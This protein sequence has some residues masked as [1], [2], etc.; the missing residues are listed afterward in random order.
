MNLDRFDGLLLRLLDV[1]FG[2]LRLLLFN[3]L[4]LLHHDRLKR[5]SLDL[6]HNLLNLMFV[7][8]QVKLKVD[9]DVLKKLSAVTLLS[10]RHLW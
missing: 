9:L 6:S 1:A 10:G 2:D 4:F 7:L 8:R 3:L 5:L